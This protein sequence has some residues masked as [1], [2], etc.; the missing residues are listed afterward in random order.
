MENLTPA[1]IDQAIAKLLESTDLAKVEIMSIRPHV[2]WNSLSWKGLYQIA[3]SELFYS[4]K[5][6]GGNGLCFG[7]YD[8]VPFFAAM[9]KSDKGL[10]GV[11]VTASTKAGSVRMG[12]GVLTDGAVSLVKSS[13]DLT[14]DTLPDP[15]K[16][17]SKRLKVLAVKMLGRR[18]LV[19]TASEVAVLVDKNITLE[20]ALEKSKKAEGKATERLEKLQKAQGVDKKPTA[21]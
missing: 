8:S 21:K 11:V 6:K 4:G 7:E 3:L 9:Y 16:A 17:V 2:G 5:L 1:T 18:N 10:C 19:T 13:S 20:L 12:Y 14:F 15:F